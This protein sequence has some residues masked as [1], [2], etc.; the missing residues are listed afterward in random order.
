VRL[1][2]ADISVIICAYTLDRYSDLVAAVDSVRQ[3][4]C[5]PS[6]IIVAIDHNDELLAR[7]LETFPELTVIPSIDPPGLS[8]ARNT[9]LALS[10]GQIVAFLDDDAIA[11]EA[12]LE[13]LAAGYSADNVLGVG[14]F[15]GPLWETERP[16][17]FPEEFDWVLGCTYRGMAEGT[18]VRNMI[19]ANMSFRRD[20]LAAVGG[21][22]HELGRMSTGISGLGDEETAACIR[23]SQLY[24]GGVFIY[25]SR[26][27]VEHRVPSSRT[28]WRYFRQR[29]YGEG[30]SKSHLARSVGSHD[31][32]SSE[33]H[34]AFVTLP[35]GV[36]RALRA[37]LGGDR[38]GL[39]RATALVGGLAYTGTGYIVGRLTRRA[40]SAPHPTPADTMTH[41]PE[42]SDDSSR[43]LRVLM[44]T[45]RYFPLVGGV[46]NHVAQVA[47]HMAGDADVTVLTADT[48]GE[49]PQSEVIDDVKI[50]RVRAWPRSRDYYFALGARRVIADGDWDLVHVQ[51]VHTAVAPIAMVAALRA[52][53]PYVLTFH[54]GGHSSQ[55]R[56]ALR[57][58]QWRV[59]RPL[60]ARARKLIAVAEFEVERFSAIL[61]L[62]R[63]RFVVIPNGS[64]LSTIA[65]EAERRLA[66]GRPTI[67]S[68]GRLERYKGHQRVIEAMPSVLRELPGS[69]LRV[70][71]SGPYQPELEQ[72][73]EKLGLVDRV[74]IQSIPAPDRKAMAQ[75]LTWGSLIVLMSEFETH[76][77][78]VVEAL[79][80][81]RPALVADTS[82]LAEI[83]RL[84]VARA[85]PLESTTDELAQAILDEV[86][87]PRTVESL[88][89]PTWQE[90]AD[91][92]LALYRDVLSSPPSAARLRAAAVRSQGE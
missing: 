64:D 9:G 67:I 51:S 28:T 2:C 25:A 82:G 73:V 79:E 35:A 10:T 76:P 58:L 14:G 5:P 81:G 90:C 39:A 62:P 13:G 88:S 26:A 74:T 16:G 59:L 18:A 23:A 22:S 38:A 48:T 21:F 80:L 15:I 65:V 72:L 69:Q 86:R 19:G 75:A 30:I 4:T 29:C 70:I 89:A 77:L 8:G 12:W 56:E 63:D 46:E 43:R 87:N 32:L 55:L 40:P 45:P 42:T 84:G 34:H 36:G 54:G 27:Q 60:L 3:Q 92:L 71:G 49:L 61:R 78:A 7:A 53:I 31:G 83:A 47:R 44:V 17:W 91:R 85:I 37:F 24:P 50:V 57:G 20:V 68:V 1:E 11:A 33:R 66:G 41:A 6:Q 52:G